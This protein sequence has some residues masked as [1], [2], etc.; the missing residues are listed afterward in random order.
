MATAAKDK[1]EEK[2]EQEN[3]QVEKEF[4][5]LVNMSA[6]QLE[7]WLG[8]EE[9][10]SVGQKKD[11]AT[12]SAGHESGKK[13]IEILSKKGKDFDEDDYSQMHRTVSY[14]KRHLAQ[15]PKEVEGSNWEYSLKNW[16]H[17]PSKK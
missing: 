5:E 15:E 6:S 9:S 16:G 3:Q 8:S 7:K 13:I 1:K 11:G 12:E 4:K 10:Q 2:Q 17:D 14:I